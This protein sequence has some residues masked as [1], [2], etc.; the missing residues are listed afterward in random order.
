[1]LEA[2]AGGRVTLNR[3][4]DKVCAQYGDARVT[5]PTVRSLEARGLLHSEP[6]T[7]VPD[8]ERVH[9]TAGGVRALAA[10]LGLRHATT[11]TTARPVMRPSATTTRSPAR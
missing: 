7:L 8:S 6:G 10:D 2:V 4:L 9:L 3:P 11:P 5:I 1:M